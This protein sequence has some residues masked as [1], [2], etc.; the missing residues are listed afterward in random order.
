MTTTKTCR[1]CGSVNTRS[2]ERMY[3]ASGDVLRWRAC[4]DCQHRFGTIEVDLPDGV[5]PFLLSQMRKYTNRMR[6]RSRRGY[7]GGLGGA[8]LKPEPVVYVTV[9]VR[10]A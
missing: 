5:T 10:A 9:R 8:P 3:S 4:R 1:K 2:R 6:V 7:H